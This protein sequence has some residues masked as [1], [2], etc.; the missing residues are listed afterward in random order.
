[1]YYDPCAHIRNNSDLSE[2]AFRDPSEMA[3]IWEHTKLGPIRKIY[4]ETLPDVV[5]ELYQA[6][7]TKK[8]GF[9]F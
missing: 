2:T 5:L 4:T 3:K 6:K 7:L 8:D 9:S 1:M